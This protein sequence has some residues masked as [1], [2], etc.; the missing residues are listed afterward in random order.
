MEA[1]R[2][3]HLNDSGSCA[4]LSLALS[5]RLGLCPFLREQPEQHSA[6]GVVGRCGQLLL[7]LLDILPDEEA[8]HRMPPRMRCGLQDSSGQKEARG[9][10]MEASRASSG[11][12]VGCAAKGGLLPGQ[13]LF[14]PGAAVELGRQRVS[15]DAGRHADDGR[16]V[17]GDR[18]RRVGGFGRAGRLP[19]ASGPAPGSPGNALRRRRNP[20]PAR[21]WDR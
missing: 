8:L 7:E 17:D 16:R 4:A 10:K 14:D 21:C 1:P 13:E 5:Q 20:T 9:R 19:Q 3:T 15:H 6:L 2:V 18:D 11:S 12:T